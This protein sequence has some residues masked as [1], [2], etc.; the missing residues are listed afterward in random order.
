[1]ARGAENAARD[2]VREID[3][4]LAQRDRLRRHPAGAAAS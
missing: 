3:E 1:M 4:T 2:L